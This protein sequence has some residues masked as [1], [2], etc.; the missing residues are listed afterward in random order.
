M[1]VFE[2]SKVMRLF[3][4]TNYFNFIR[5]AEC[6]KMKSPKSSTTKYQ[7]CG[8]YLYPYFSCKESF[9]NMID[10]YGTTV[11][12]INKSV[13]YDYPWTGDIRQKNGIN[14]MITNNNIED[15]SMNIAILNTISPKYGEILIQKNELN[16]QS[17][18]DKV[19]IPKNMPKIFN[20]DYSNIPVHTYD[21][22]L[23]DIVDK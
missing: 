23:L 21:F 5:I 6:G 16:I 19:Y 14:H 18:L 15:T 1:C 10:T 12:E 13:L 9:V 22:T 7:R 17:Y 4:F 11:L 3:H 20:H 2:T 8:I